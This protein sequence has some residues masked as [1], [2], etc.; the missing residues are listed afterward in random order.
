MV[1]VI[2]HTQA[3]QTAAMQRK[4]AT[5]ARRVGRY[6]NS[7]LSPIRRSA[8][9][10]CPPDKRNLQWHACIRE[11]PLGAGTSAPIDCLLMLAGH[12]A[13]NNSLANRAP[14][15][16]VPGTA[17][18]APAATSAAPLPNDQTRGVPGRDL[19]TMSSNSWERTKCVTPAVSNSAASINAAMLLGLF[20]R[21]RAVPISDLGRA[22]PTVTVRIRRRTEHPDLAAI[23]RRSLPVMIAAMI[24]YG[25]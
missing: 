25:Q 13:V 10:P 17:T 24:R 14:R 20:M 7:A 3:R 6:R 9:P 23:Q 2:Q 12:T 15:R 5:G 8:H 18:S 4:L 22:F 1:F 19:G 11:R 21:T 16:R